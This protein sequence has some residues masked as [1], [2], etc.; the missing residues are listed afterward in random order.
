MGYE[1]YKI[2]AK[3]RDLTTEDMISAL[4]GQGA[5]FTE[6]FGGTV[7][8]EIAGEHG[9]IE[10]VIREDSHVNLRF[11]PEDKVL[12]TVRFAKASDVQIVP[13]V[14]ALLKKLAAAFDAVYIRD[15]QANRD[16]NPGDTAWLLQAVTFAKYD[17]EYRYPLRRHHLRCRDVFCLC[18][19]EY[20]TAP[21]DAFR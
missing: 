8:M 12:L 10:L 1:A 7:T 14:V 3:F 18:G 9:F 19:T 5:V 11:S 21:A 15:C 2:S 13:A 6:R 4:R 20:P 16:I 17:F